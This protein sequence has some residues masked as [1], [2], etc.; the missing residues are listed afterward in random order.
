[1]LCI[2]DDLPEVRYLDLDSQALELEDGGTGGMPRGWLCQVQWVVVAAKGS[3]SKHLYTIVV[4][5]QKE[6]SKKERC[7]NGLNKMGSTFFLSAG[8]PGPTNPSGEW[9]QGTN[10][11]LR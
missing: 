5:Q 1:M 10:S 9:V 7:S 4:S 3:K 11:V 6:G 8:N 2:N